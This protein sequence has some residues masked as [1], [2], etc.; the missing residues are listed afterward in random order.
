MTVILFGSRGPIFE[1]RGE[2]LFTLSP[3][4]S[5]IVDEYEAPKKD[6]MW[7][8]KTFLKETIHIVVVFRD[9]NLAYI[10]AKWIEDCNVFKPV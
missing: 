2:K 7:G 9:L 6:C 10:L 8:K 3:T 1:N 5:Q 4:F